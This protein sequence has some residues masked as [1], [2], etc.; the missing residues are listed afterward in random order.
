VEICPQR[1]RVA[2]TNRI[3]AEQHWEDRKTQ[4]PFRVKYEAHNG[5]YVK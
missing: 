2:Q 3:I 5:E 1:P 4:K